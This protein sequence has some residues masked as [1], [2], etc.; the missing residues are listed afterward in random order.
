[1][2][3]LMFMGL[4]KEV[5]QN[6]ESF[7]TD[8]NLDFLNFEIFLDQSDSELLKKV[9]YYPYNL[10]INGFRLVL[11]TEQTDKS[12]LDAK[13]VALVCCGCGFFLAGDE[14]TVDVDLTEK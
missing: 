7:F 13:F 14:E 3:I 6:W 9:D 2:D 11:V 10:D 8:L 12:L 4:F 5:W 1:M